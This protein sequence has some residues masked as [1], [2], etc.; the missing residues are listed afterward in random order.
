[1]ITTRGSAISHHDHSRGRHP[2]RGYR[3]RLA[4]C[5][6]DWDEDEDEEL[7]IGNH[8][9]RWGGAR[10]SRRLGRS[11][12]WIGAAVAL[13]TVASTMRKKGVISG[14]LDTGLNAVPVVGAAKNLVEIARG[15]DFFPDRVAD[16]TRLPQG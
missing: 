10:L 4:S 12:P 1:M 3:P 6:G 2:G 11:L 15:R 8:V 9:V 16:R 13:A 5:Y 14:V 7:S